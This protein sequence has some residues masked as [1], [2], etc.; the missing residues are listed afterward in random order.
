MQC[1]YSH[2]SLVG[3]AAKSLDQDLFSTSKLGLI[4]SKAGADLLGALDIGESLATDT[5]VSLDHKGGVEALLAPDDDDGSVIRNG[6]L[7][8]ELGSTLKLHSAG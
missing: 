7:N 1:S 8:G 5:L 2:V 6:C 4:T 3:G